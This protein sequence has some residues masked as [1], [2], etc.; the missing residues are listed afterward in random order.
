MTDEREEDA[1]ALH[2]VRLLTANNEGV[3]HPPLQ[4]FPFLWHETYHQDHDYDEVYKT[5]RGQIGL[6]VR[7]ER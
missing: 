1:D 3:K 4:A 2:C 5:V 6:V 7:V